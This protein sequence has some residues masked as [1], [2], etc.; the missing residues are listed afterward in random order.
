MVRYDLW[1]SKRQTRWYDIP[2]GM[3]FNEVHV[4]IFQMSVVINDMVLEGTPTTLPDQCLIPPWTTVVGATLIVSAEKRATALNCN[5]AL[6]TLG[7]LA[8]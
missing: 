1:G 2:V 6:L 5:R 8:A 3:L 4:K 7:Q